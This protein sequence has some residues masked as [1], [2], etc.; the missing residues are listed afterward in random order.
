MQL[1]DMPGKETKR[2]PRSAVAVL[3]PDVLAQ[4]LHAIGHDTHSTRTIVEWL[5]AEGHTAVTDGSLEYFIRNSPDCPQRGS[6]RGQ[7]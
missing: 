3:P 6:L 1:A 2:Q 7:S 5:H 4:V